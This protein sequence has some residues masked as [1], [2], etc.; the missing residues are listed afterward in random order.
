MSQ[1][2][3]QLHIGFIQSNTLWK[4][5]SANRIHLESLFPKNADI[6]I[7]PE[8][9][10]TGFAMDKNLA[11]PMTGSSVQWLLEM[12]AKHQAVVCGSLFI[13]EGEKVFNRFIWV[14]EDGTLVHYDKRHLFSL[15]GEDREFNPGHQQI[16]IPFKGWNIRPL[17]CYDLRFPVWSRNTKNTDLM[18]YVANWPER[19]V[20][21]W[22]QLLIARAIENQCY[23]IGVNRVGE[24]GDG[25]LYTGESALIDPMGK[26]IQQKSNEEAMVLEVID[27][28]YLNNMRSKL[29][30]QSDQDDFTI[31]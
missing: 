23:V 29:N 19:R 11:E 14:K 12:A 27:F 1:L 25:V 31:H 4:N 22:S 13:K 16:I 30:F 5:P 21:A 3:K 26:V 7:L 17:I 8:T 9:F 15:A 20:Y 10:N 28:D 6:I 24:D 18:I 2:K